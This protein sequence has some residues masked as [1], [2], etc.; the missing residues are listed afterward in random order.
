MS[1]IKYMAMNLI[2]NAPGKDSIKARR[3]AAG[4]ERGYLQALITRTTP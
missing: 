3:K 4:W 1:I 2:R